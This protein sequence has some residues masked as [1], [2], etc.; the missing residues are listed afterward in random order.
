[1]IP[2]STSEDGQKEME[3][4]LLLWFLIKKRKN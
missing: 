4:M 1:M 2:K 3:T